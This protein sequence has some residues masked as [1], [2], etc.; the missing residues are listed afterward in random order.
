METKKNDLKPY[1]LDCA[2]KALEC[3]GWRLTRDSSS[4]YKLS[5]NQESK[6]LAIRTTQ[7][8]LVGFNRSETK[9]GW[10]TLD[11]GRE[12]EP[13]KVED[14]V[15]V[16]IDKE[17]TLIRVHKI[18]VKDVREHFDKAFKIR[19]E[20]AS[21]EG[22]TPPKLLFL[23]LYKPEIKGKPKTTG[24]GLGLEEDTLIKEFDFKTSETAGDEHNSAHHVQSIHPSQNVPNEPGLTISEA[25]KRLAESLGVE[26]D[27]IKISIIEA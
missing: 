9:D 4:I 21:Q 25:K 11:F 2:K 19:E 12:D 16:S 15:F 1:L 26:P 14:V 27:C 8:E 6:I 5:R 13:S 18:P 24:W 20:K 10:Q 17:R 23:P 3:D 7:N 22:K